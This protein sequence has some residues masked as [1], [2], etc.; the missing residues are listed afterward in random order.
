MSFHLFIFFIFFCSYFTIFMDGFNK[1]PKRNSTA[2]RVRK[3]YVVN[4]F[5]F[6]SIKIVIIINISKTVK[7]TSDN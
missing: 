6:C 7:N 1:L 2:D 3:Y 4:I 5:S